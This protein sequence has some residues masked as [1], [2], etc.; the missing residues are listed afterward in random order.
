M[1]NDCRGGRGCVAHADDS[2]HLESCD[3]SESRRRF[4]WLPVGDPRHDFQRGGRIINLASLSALLAPPG[5]TNY[6]AAKAGVVALTQSLAKEV[7]A[8]ASP[9]MPSVPAAWKPN[10]WPRWTKKRAARC[11]RKS[12]CEGLEDPRRWRRR[13][14]FWLAPMPLTSQALSSK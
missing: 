2:G 3:F 12:P 8:S 10:R 9:S 6:A 7:A 11:W 13:C 14:D 4:S 5:Q 1:V